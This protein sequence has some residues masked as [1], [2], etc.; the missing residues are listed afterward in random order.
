MPELRHDPIQHRWVIIASERGHRPTD[1]PPEILPPGDPASCPLCPGNEAETPPEI[2]AFRDGTARDEPGW[3]VRV[4]PNKF[5]ALAIEG[6]LDRRANGHYDRVNGIGAHEVIVESPT[7]DLPLAAQPTAHIQLVLQAYRE[8]LR[9][10]MNDT[11]LRYILIF[12]NHG[13]AAGASLHHSHSQLI[14]TPVTPRTVAMELQTA[15]EHFH[16]KERCLF[17]DLTYQ[18]LAQGERIVFADEHFV[19]FCPYASRFAYEMTLLPR[20]HAHDFSESND[21]LLGH[22]ARHLKQVLTRMNYA[23]GDPAYNFVLHTA[24]NTRG[25]V[26]RQGY[27]GTLPDDWHWHLEILPRLTKVA[28]FEWGTGFYINPTPPEEAAAHLRNAPD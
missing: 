9:D 18:E 23:L 3:D 19:T 17:C 20:R 6:E 10:L 7:H 4:V 15:R 12:K 27:W 1:F 26:T 21:E 25:K 2:M 11:R 13:A 5:P 14:A 8:R 28:G 22:L 16:L 24:P